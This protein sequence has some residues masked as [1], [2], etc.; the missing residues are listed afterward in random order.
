MSLLNK[1]TPKPTVVAERGEYFKNS[2]GEVL[3]VSPQ[4]P[5]HD[6]TYLVSEE[7]VA[8]V[9]SRKGGVVIDADTV[10]SASRENRP[11]KSKHYSD[12]D[13]SLEIESKEAQAFAKDSWGLKIKTKGTISP[14]KLID[15]AMDAR[16]SLLNK[17]KGKE[18][19][20][21]SS[22]S[23][24]TNL[25]NKAVLE[26][27]PDLEKIYDDVF[28]LQESKRVSDEKGNYA[29]TGMQYAQVASIQ[30]YGFKSPQTDKYTSQIKDA[31]TI[32]YPNLSVTRKQQ[33]G[34]TLRE[35]TRGPL[36][37]YIDE[38]T[39]PFRSYDKN[40]SH[41][42]KTIVN[43]L[44]KKYPSVKDKAS[45]LTAAGSL[46]PNPYIAIPS[47][48]INTGIDLFDKNILEAGSEI[49]VAI[50]KS[51][52]GVKGK[53]LGNI[54]NAVSSY[55]D[56]TNTKTV[57]IDKYAAQSLTKKQQ[58][59]KTKLKPVPYM[60]GSRPA[61]GTTSG[62]S[63]EV[64]DGRTVSMDQ[65][66]DSDSVVVKGNEGKTFYKSKLSKYVK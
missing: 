1:Y 47:T 8:R 28:Q 18:G 34:H 44:N 32:M 20:K 15:Q 43:F 14:S 63:I 50:W 57:N 29:Q 59:G 10:V 30:D 16:T 37:Q 33:G 52:S 21:H 31:G 11:K 22:L 13:K 3:K 9:P 51:A 53:V 7:E 5:T 6:D 65:I 25:A 24:T 45:A 61:L 2:E 36:K 12:E 23:A 38:L 58:G 55:D 62:R 4:M 42:L 60:K 56:L 35:D 19:L 27:L 46:V 49:P 40:V 26:T 41:D 54:M 64:L 66:Y 17:Y 48:L 39:L